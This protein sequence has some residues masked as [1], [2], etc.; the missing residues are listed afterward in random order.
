M[1]K[2]QYSKS[3]ITHPDNDFGRTKYTF[4]AYAVWLLSDHAYQVRFAKLAYAPQLP[5]RQ[6][7]FRSDLGIRH[8][9]TNF[10]R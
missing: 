6:H 2:N 3:E 1:V 7:D 5:S 10:Q 8:S 4:R 9:S